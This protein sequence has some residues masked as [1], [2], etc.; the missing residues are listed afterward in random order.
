MKRRLGSLGLVVVMSVLATASPT[1]N[2][3]AATG[4]VF[5][6]QSPYVANVYAQ[7]PGHRP[8]QKDTG[9]PRTI[10]AKEVAAGLHW[11]YVWVA[12]SDI[13]QA[14]GVYNWGDLDNF[15]TAA[16]DSGIELGFQVTL[17]HWGLPQP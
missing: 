14:Q 2:V 8:W 10:M 7:L 12:W 5:D 3:G 13:E 4:P 9:D 16:H 1:T 15:V 11:N 6:H 17:G